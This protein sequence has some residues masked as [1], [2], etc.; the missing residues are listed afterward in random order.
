MI[1]EC[2]HVLVDRGLWDVLHFLIGTKKL[3]VHCPGLGQF[4]TMET[5]MSRFVTKFRWI[6][7]Q[8]LGRL[9]K[10]SIILLCQP[11]MQH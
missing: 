7:E 3:N 11:I 8:V 6:I 9:T 1:V 2:D 4:E 5:N 10:S